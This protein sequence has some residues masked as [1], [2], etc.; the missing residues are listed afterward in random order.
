MNKQSSRVGPPSTSWTPKRATSCAPKIKLLTTLSNYPA[1][2]PTLLCVAAYF[3][4]LSINS[5][6]IFHYL[7]TPFP[8][9][10]SKKE[11]SLGKF[12]RWAGNPRPTQGYDRLI[13]NLIFLLRFESLCFITASLVAFIV[14]I[15]IIIIIVFMIIVIVH[16][17]FCLGN[18]MLFCFPLIHLVLFIPSCLIFNYLFVPSLFL[19]VWISTFYSSFC[20][21]RFTSAFL[22]YFYSNSIKHVYAFLT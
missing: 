1:L 2:G 18:A 20:I 7:R 6:L 13:F 5:T 19:N 12:N 14:F 11:T 16:I 21:C 22:Y 17:I 10:I 3:F 4:P 15:I 9:F 8:S